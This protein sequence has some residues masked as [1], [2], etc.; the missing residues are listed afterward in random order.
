MTSTQ[1]GVGSTI[2]VVATRTGLSMDTL[3]VWERRYGFPA[4]KRR[5]GSNRRLYDDAD[6]EK[7]VAIARAIERG[8]RVGD[9]VDRSVEELSTLG[10]VD[11]AA[12][13][14]GAMADVADL[15]QFLERDEVIAFESELRRLGAALGARRFVMDVAHPLA[16]GVGAAWEEGRLAVRHEHVATECLATQLRAM[17]AGYQDLDVQPRVVLATLPGEPHTLVLDM[18]A[19]YLAVSGA[20]PR[21]IGSSTPPSE[22]VDGVIAFK[23]DVVGISV[24]PTADRVVTRRQIRSVLQ[25][26]PPRVPLWIGGSGA[27]D[28]AIDHEAVVVATTWSAVTDAIVA[29]RGRMRGRS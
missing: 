17:L 22:I 13:G 19:L 10:A 18:V 12:S 28:L 15:I 27:A 25:G 11:P 5:E 1:K 20:K 4:P 21:L 9:I 8:Y 14:P 29:W 2:R 3:R 23:G 24:G 16:V 7:L 6:V 26:L